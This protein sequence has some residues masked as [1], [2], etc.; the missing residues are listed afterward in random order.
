MA[1]SIFTTSEV[2][3]KLSSVDH[4]HH[5][6]VYAARHEHGLSEHAVIGMIGR[7]QKQAEPPVLRSPG[8]VPRRTVDRA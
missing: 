6:W 7:R 2:I 5:A 4:D 1:C 8:P 3:G